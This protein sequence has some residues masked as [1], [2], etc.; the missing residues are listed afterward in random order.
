MAPID[1]AIEDLES[2]DHVDKSMYREVALKYSCDRS[3]V[4]QR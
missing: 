1:D 4:S 3:T 2:R